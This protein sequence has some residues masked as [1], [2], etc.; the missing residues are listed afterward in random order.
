[1]NYK[2][3]FIVIMFLLIS[4]SS[5]KLQN[6]DIRPCVSK[7]C[8]DKSYVY[9]SE[10]ISNDTFNKDFSDVNVYSSNRT[11]VGNLRDSFQIVARNFIDLVP[12]LPSLS[13]YILESGNL[14]LLLQ[15]PNSLPEINEISNDKFC[16]DYE[17][18]SD[19]F[20]PVFGVIFEEEPQKNLVF[21]IAALLISSVLLLL[22]LIIY[23]LIKELRNLKGQ[24]LMANVFSLLCA[25]VMLATVKILYN[26]NSF[27]AS[28]EFCY[29]STAAIYFFFLSTFYW[30]NITSF[31]I[32]WT[33]RSMTTRVT[34]RRHGRCSKFK[35]YCFYG[36]GIPLAMAIGLIAIDVCEL[37][38]GFIKPNIILNGCFLAGKPKLFYMH[39][40]MMLVITSNCMFFL[41]TAYNFWCIGRDTEMLNC[42]NANKHDRQKQRFLIYL[43]L[44]IV[45]GISWVTELIS[46]YLPNLSVWYITD[47]Y[48][49]FIGIS[50]FFIFV[51]KKDIRKQLYKRFQSS[52]TAYSSHKLIQSS[53][54]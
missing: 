24:I 3:N 34:V 25:F 9:N 38:E 36:W 10:C 22:V 49:M 14:N 6:Y 29:G 21:T 53:S 42:H 13:F 15:Q 12:N 44:S 37:P 40:P 19:N 39:I 16:V 48:N 4:D 30:M 18:A 47:A 20:S 32:W 41:M 45:M 50:I 1:M 26:S 27:E 2:L 33:L 17:L 46:A 11:R 5:E 31:D 52:R 28:T 23:A 8:P 43:K 7:C 54:S 35:I 51:C